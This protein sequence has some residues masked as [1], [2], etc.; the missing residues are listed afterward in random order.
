[1]DNIV[2]QEYWTGFNSEGILIFHRFKYSDGMC[3]SY[4]DEDS[5]SN[6]L[7]FSQFDECPK[8]YVT[9]NYIFYAEYPNTLITL[10]NHIANFTE[11]TKD[12][13]NSRLLLCRSIFNYIKKAHG[14][15]VSNLR[16][17]S[18]EIYII[19]NQIKVY[20]PT[21]LHCMDNSFIRSEQDDNDELVI[22]PRNGFE[23][24]LLDFGILVASIF[25]LNIPYYGT[26]KR[27]SIIRKLE[28]SVKES[29]NPVAPVVFNLVKNI[30]NFD[31]TYQNFDRV[32]NEL[33]IIFSHI[34]R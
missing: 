12:T 13:Q 8:I 25:S 26:D 1:M 18:N 17:K 34:N 22:E 31:I 23:E 11:N 9:E 16:I 3:R 5:K 6:F 10:E 2:C 29:K 20:F 14:L 33:R 7:K 30:L 19:G 15:N 24:D 4:Y 32:E 27:I 21:D 28:N